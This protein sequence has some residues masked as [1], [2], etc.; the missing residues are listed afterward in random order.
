MGRHDGEA[1]AQAAVRERDAAEGRDGGGAGDARDKLAAYALS[2]ERHELL[3]AAPEYER[4]AALQPHDVQPARGVF[5]HEP[6]YPVLP[7][8]GPARAL[9]DIYALRALRGGGEEP[10]V[11]EIVVQHRAAAAEALEP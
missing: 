10:G 4:V 5:G 8:A 3:A 2:V 11:N 6:D 1:P 7:G 9:A